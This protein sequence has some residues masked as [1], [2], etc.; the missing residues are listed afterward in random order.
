MLTF[1]FLAFH[2]VEMDQ[3]PLFE[4]PPYSLALAVAIH[5]TAIN[6]GLDVVHVHY[7]IPHAYA[8]YMAKQMLKE[9][10]IHI[11]IVTTLHGTRF[12]MADET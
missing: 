8:A 6:Q 3:Y 12:L 1:H 5:D 9:K 4:H 10:G 11:P 7:A 2:E